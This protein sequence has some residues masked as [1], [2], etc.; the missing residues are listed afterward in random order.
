MAKTQIIQDIAEKLHNYRYD[1]YLSKDKIYGFYTDGKRVVSFGGSWQFCVDFS[2]NYKQSKESGTGWSIA[3]ELTDISEEQ[4]NA[5]INANAP[6]WT[7]NKN[8]VYTTPDQ[9]M[10]TYGK[11]SGYAKFEPV[12]L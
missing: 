8:P 9:H 2:G 10:A 7:R 5:F 6:S 3:K 12:T 4:A 1:V 11:S